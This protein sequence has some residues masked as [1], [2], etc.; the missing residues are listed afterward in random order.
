MQ[1]HN[2]LLKSGVKEPNEEKEQ[3]QHH[4]ELL[5]TGACSS[6]SALNLRGQAASLSV[7]YGT[8]PRCIPVN[9]DMRVPCVVRGECRA[10]LLEFEK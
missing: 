9:I 10:A 6:A 7:G 3:V 5:K 1:H 4:N 8:F 2:E